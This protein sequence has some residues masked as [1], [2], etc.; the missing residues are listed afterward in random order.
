[1][2]FGSCVRFEIGRGVILTVGS[3]PT[4]SAIW[5]FMTDFASLCVFMGYSGLVVFLCVAC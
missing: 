4:F 3:N 5:S 2:V 1:M